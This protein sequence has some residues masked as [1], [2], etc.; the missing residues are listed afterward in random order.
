MYSCLARAQLNKCNCTE[1]KFRFGVNICSE[2]SQGKTTFSES[3]MN[4]TGQAKSSALPV[5]Y[6]AATISHHLTYV[7]KCT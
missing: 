7:Q 5:R 6:K 2:T 3:A 4:N 1:G